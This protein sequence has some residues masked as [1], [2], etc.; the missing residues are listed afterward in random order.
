METWKRESDSALLQ[1]RAGAHR[2]ERTIAY[3]LEV[4]RRAS[5]AAVLAPLI[6][7]SGRAIGSGCLKWMGAGSSKVIAYASGYR[8]EVGVIY[9]GRNTPEGVEWIRPT[10]ARD[11]KLIEG[12]VRHVA[13]R[14]GERSLAP[15]ASITINGLG[16]GG[17]KR[18]AS[19]VRMAPLRD[20]ASALGATVIFDVLQGLATV[21]KGQRSV[22]L[23]LSCKEAYEG[24]AR[25]SLGAE[26]VR[27]E[28]EWYVPLDSI[29]ALLN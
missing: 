1:V 13:G 24:E 22:V 15:G 12:L 27:S 10:Y 2:T 20:F 17:M 16:I 4:E 3:Y 18:T 8:I 26:V 23:G 19:G 7:P 28:S 9:G 21:K 14:L 25:H 6:S 11:T 5:N 29:L